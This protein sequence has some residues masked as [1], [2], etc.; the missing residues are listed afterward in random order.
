MSNTEPNVV[1]EPTATEDTTPAK[2]GLWRSFRNLIDWFALE[3]VVEI[4]EEF[5]VAIALMS[6]VLGLITGGA[7]LHHSP[8]GLILFGVATGGGVFGI[9]RTKGVESR[10]RLYLLSVCALAFGLVGCIGWLIPRVG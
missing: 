4:M 9:W 3:A 6:G 5:R 1:T 2:T 10:S 8:V 7:W